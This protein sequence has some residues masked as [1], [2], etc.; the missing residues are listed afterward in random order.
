M[1]EVGTKLRSIRSGKVVEVL[2]LLSG[3]KKVKFEDG[4][5]KVLNDSNVARWY[6]EVKEA[7]AEPKEQPKAEPKVATKVKT[8]GQTLNKVYQPKNNKQEKK[9]GKDLTLIG[10]ELLV[11][12]KSF[13]NKNSFEAYEKKEYSGVR[14]SGK[15]ICHFHLLRKKMKFEFKSSDICDEDKKI[16]V[17]Y[18]EHFK[19]VYC[20]CVY[21]KTQDDLKTVLNLLERISKKGE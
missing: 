19:R 16:M 6:D 7:K 8:G 15:C 14:V 18:P 11:S 9:D 2:E 20:Y 5:V 21:A 4:I 13:L 17:K 1:I 12:F 3:A 10:A